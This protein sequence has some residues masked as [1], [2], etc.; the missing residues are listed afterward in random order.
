MVREELAKYLSN[1]VCSECHGARL[2]QAARNVFVQD[3]ALNQLTALPIRK[4]LAFFKPLS[5]PGKR[6][7]VAD[8]KVEDA[9][10]REKGKME[11][12]DKYFKDSLKKSEKKPPEKP[13]NPMDLD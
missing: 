11:R 9:K 7:E 13:V 1:K 10:A 2:N 5:L 6:G 3:T 12:L 8:Q 4:S